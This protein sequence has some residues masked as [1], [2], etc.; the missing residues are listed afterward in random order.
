MKSDAEAMFRN[1]ASSAANLT[2]VIW[3]PHPDVEGT[4]NWVA[5]YTNPNYYKWAI[6]FK[7][8]PE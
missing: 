3:N 6:C 5:S 7:E 1:W 4:R 2:Y 8:N